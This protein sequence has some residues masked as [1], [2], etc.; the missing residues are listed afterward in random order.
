MRTI[1]LES[2]NVTIKQTTFPSRSSLISRLVGETEAHKQQAAT[3]HVRDTGGCGVVVKHW[4]PGEAKRE[5]Q[6]L[7][8]RIR[9]M[10]VCVYHS[11]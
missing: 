2:E 3:G 10:G 6:A 7:A 1:V 9:G 5:G 4:L 8:G 11:G